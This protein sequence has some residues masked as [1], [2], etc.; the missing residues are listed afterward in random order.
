MR[1]E[2]AQAVVLDSLAGFS[3]AHEIQARALVRPLSRFLQKWH[4]TARAASQTR[5]GHERSTAEATGG[6]AV[7][8]ILDRSPVLA[9]RTGLSS[10]Q[11]RLDRTTLGET[12]RLL[13]IDGCPMSGHDI[14][15]H[16]LESTAEGLVR[17]GHRRSELARDTSTN[18]Q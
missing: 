10:Q 14:A 1:T 13:R 8:D 11:A 4:Q 16:L 6:F 12:V 9:Q 15:T 17:I 7:G 5:C 18:G 2:H 3:E